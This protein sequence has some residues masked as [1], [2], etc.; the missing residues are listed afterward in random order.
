[1]NDHPVLLNIIHGISVEFTNS[2]K[3]VESIFHWIKAAKHGKVK[4]VDR[5]LLPQI[6]EREELISGLELSESKEF[7]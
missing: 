3:S 5:Q 7:S 6:R 4:Y 1:M 2:E